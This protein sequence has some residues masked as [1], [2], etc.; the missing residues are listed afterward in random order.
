MTYIAPSRGSRETLWIQRASKCVVFKERGKVGIRLVAFR[1]AVS[2]SDM[3]IHCATPY[4]LNTPIISCGNNLHSSVNKTA[5]LAEL[6]RHLYTDIPQCF[7]FDLHIK[8]NTIKSSPR[9][10]SS[11]DWP[12]YL[13]TPYTQSQSTNTRQNN[14]TLDTTERTQPNGIGIRSIAGYTSH[15]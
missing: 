5:E 14:D 12:R 4:I 7:L 2:V 1:F 3:K 6:K 10:T 9:T 13:K 11:L 8:I 15:S